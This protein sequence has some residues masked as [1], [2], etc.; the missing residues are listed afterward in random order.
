MQHDH[1]TARTQRIGDCIENL[2]PMGIIQNSTIGMSDDVRNQFFDDSPPP[3]DDVNLL[4][5]TG[6]DCYA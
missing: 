5:S 1:G 2:V 3:F 4:R 6:S